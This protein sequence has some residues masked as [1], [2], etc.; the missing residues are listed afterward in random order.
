MLNDG[1]ESAVWLVAEGDR[2][3]WSVVRKTEDRLLFDDEYRR[4]AYDWEDSTATDRYA[5]APRCANLKCK[6]AFRAGQ[7]IAYVPYCSLHHQFLQANERG[8]LVAG[9]NAGINIQPRRQLPTV[10]QD[11]S[12]VRAVHGG[13]GH[14]E[15]PAAGLCSRGK[16]FGASVVQSSSGSTMALQRRSQETWKHF[17]CPVILLTCGPTPAPALNRVQ[18][19]RL[20]TM[21]TFGLQEPLVPADG[22]HFE[23]QKACPQV[24][25]TI[26][27]EP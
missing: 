27:A 14:A 26:L 22:C 13:K 25:D 15:A 12:R 2:V 9:T 10:C 6:L 5:T 23:R 4:V 18:G 16:G 7:K 19:A 17:E 3:A 24:R 21:L 1:D 20:L 8:T 11:G